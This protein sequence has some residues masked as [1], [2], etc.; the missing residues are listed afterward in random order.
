MARKPGTWTQGHGGAS[1]AD[2]P[3]SSWWLLPETGLPGPWR[4]DPASLRG[5]RQGCGALAADHFRRGRTAGAPEAKPEGWQP[6]GAA[7]AGLWEPASR[8]SLLKPEQGHK[9]RVPGLS[10]LSPPGGPLQ[11]PPHPLR[12]SLRW[13]EVTRAWECRCQCS[14]HQRWHISWLLPKF[15][16]RINHSLGLK[17]S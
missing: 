3:G 14:W 10:E 7:Q 12:P 5:Q 16:D 15:M 2:P 1:R 8:A 9:M 17:L 11:H 4:A 13:D 6:Q